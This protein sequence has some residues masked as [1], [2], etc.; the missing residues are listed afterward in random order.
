MARPL[1]SVSSHTIAPF[2][3][4]AWPLAALGAAALSSFACSGGDLGDR[5]SDVL[6]AYGGGGAAATGQGAPGTSTGPNASNGQSTGQTN[7]PGRVSEVPGA[8]PYAQPPLQPSNNPGNTS[9]AGGSSAVAPATGTGGAGGS[10][11]VPPVGAG[12]A[13][14]VPPVNGAAGA[15][16]TTPP[17]S[18]APDIACP[19]D[20]TF[21]SGFESDTLADGATYQSNPMATLQFDTAVKRS[22]NRSLMVVSAG[23]FNIREVVTS[24]PGQ[25]F[26]VRLFIQTSNVFGD[27]NHDSLFVASTASF[28]QDNNAESGPEFSEQGNQILLNA[29]DGLFSAAGRGFPQANTGPTLSANTWHCVEAFYDG[30]SGDSQFFTDGTQIINAAAFTPRNYQTFRFGYIGFNTVRTVWFDDVVVASNRIGCN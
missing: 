2:R 9:G 3:S 13:A 24:I 14:T 21:C 29:D 8:A 18:T 10:A 25:S 20:A 12:G 5:A 23:N 22:G 15:P 7:T 17:P 4:V 16:S 27:N 30:A 1:R 28:T 11:T 19:N 6:P 26:W